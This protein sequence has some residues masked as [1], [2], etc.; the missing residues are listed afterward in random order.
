MPENYLL[1]PFAEL[2]AAGRVREIE[3]AVIRGTEVGIHRLTETWCIAP[4][5]FPGSR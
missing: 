5:R 3:W 4:G 2:V 1:V